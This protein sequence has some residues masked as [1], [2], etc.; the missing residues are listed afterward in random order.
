MAI[1]FEK[2]I[3]F[4]HNHKYHYHTY[5]V[6][7]SITCDYYNITYIINILISLRPKPFLKQKI[8]IPEPYVFY[9]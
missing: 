1:I 8:C 5:Y 3:S 7:I 2:V 4:K 6:I 9:C